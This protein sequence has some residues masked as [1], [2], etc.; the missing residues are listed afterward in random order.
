MK[1]IVELI[2]Y[3][4]CSR[5]PKKY[6]TNDPDFEK[7]WI[8]QTKKEKTHYTYENGRCK[9]C[10]GIDINMIRDKPFFYNELIETMNH[11]FL[12]CFLVIEVNPDTS[13]YLDNLWYKYEDTELFKELLIGLSYSGIGWPESK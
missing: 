5:A 7:K 8:A 9:I 1:S 2:D 4:I 3:Y 10:F 13:H 12:H 11:E 6:N